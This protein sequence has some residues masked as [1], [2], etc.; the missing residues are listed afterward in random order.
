VAG[1]GSVVKGSSTAFGLD[2]KVGRIGAS[3]VHHGLGRATRYGAPSEVG[4]FR[5]TGRV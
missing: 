5:S 3:G 4:N 2:V 1:E